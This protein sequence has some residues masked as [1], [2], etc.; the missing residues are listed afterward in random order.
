MRIRTRTGI[1]DAGLKPLKPSRHDRDRLHGSWFWMNDQLTAGGPVVK[2]VWKRNCAA[3]G[4]LKKPDK[5]WPSGS[6]WRMMAKRSVLL[7][8]THVLKWQT[9]QFLTTTAFLWRW[10]AEMQIANANK[11]KRKSGTAFLPF[12]VV[13]AHGRMR[14]KTHL[15]DVTKKLPIFRMIVNCDYWSHLMVI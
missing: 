12:P 6:D 8:W 7:I 9:A 4:N 5:K 2:I 3:G 13:P 1:G 11:T 14:I 10:N 15:A